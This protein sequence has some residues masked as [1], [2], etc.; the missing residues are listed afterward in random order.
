MMDGASSIFKSSDLAMTIIG[1]VRIDPD[2]D[3]EDTIED[4]QLAANGAELVLS[5]LWASEQGALTPVL[6]SDVQE[7]P[8]LNQTIRVIKEKLGLGRGSTPTTSA[9]RSEDGD[10]RDA[11]VEAWAV[12]SASIVQELNRMHESRTSE[13]NQKE[14]KPKG[15]EPV[16]V[17]SSRSRSEGAIHD[18][19]YRRHVSGTSDDNVYVHGYHD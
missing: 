11:R 8:Y 3:D 5:F 19:V 10:N 18:P 6:L 2:E 16:S 12:S 14:A 4:K 1:M 7:N 17:E 15:S 9:S 13:R